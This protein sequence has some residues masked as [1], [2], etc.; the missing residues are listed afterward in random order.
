MQEKEIKAQTFRLS[1]ESTEK[2]RR[3]CEENGI[4]QA[5]GFESLLKTAELEKAKTA[6]PDRKA[7]IENVQT[8]ANISA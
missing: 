6:I 7:E 3:F 2:F 5:E 4:S 8:H 1:T